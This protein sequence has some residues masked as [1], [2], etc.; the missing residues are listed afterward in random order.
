VAFKTFVDGVALPAS[1]LNTYLMKQAV[2]V[3]TSAT[4]PA[5]PLEGQ[6]IYETDTDRMLTYTTAT[7]TWRQPWNL[8]WGYITKTTSNASTTGIT[9]EVD[10]LTVTWTA[11][12]NRRYKISLLMHLFQ[13]TTIAT[14]MVAITDNSLTHLQEWQQYAGVDERFTIN[15]FVEVSPASGSVT[16]RGRVATSASTIDLNGQTTT[17]LHYM[18]VEDMG[19]AG[20]PA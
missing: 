16:Y 14:P 6:Q 20:A 8:P 7:T 11:V 5:S 1:D 19:P 10:V 15:S 18:L 12:A 9:T 3:C 4:R 2:I 17:R 13:R